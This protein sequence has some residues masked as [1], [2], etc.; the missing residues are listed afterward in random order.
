MTRPVA[1]GALAAA[2]LL[3]ILLSFG[4]NGSSNPTSERK[5]PRKGAVDQPGAAFSQQRCGEFLEQAWDML[6]PDRL[7]VSAERSVA[8]S[9]LNQWLLGCGGQ[10][11]VAS[12]MEESQARLKELIAPAAW[13]RTQEQ[14]FALRDADHI[15]NAILF[16]EINQFVPAGAE[17]DVQRVARLFDYVVRNVALKQPQERLPLTPHQILMFGRGSAED[18][19]WLFAELLRQARIDSVVVRP[20]AGGDEASE[21][22]AG[23]EWYVGAVLG[24]DVYLFDPRRGAPVPSAS[25]GAS[26]AWPLAPAKLSE[27]V[28]D[29]ADSAETTEA[30]RRRM[31]LIG[32]STYWSERMQKLQESLSGERSIVIYDPAVGQ[33][34]ERGGLARAEAAA[35]TGWQIGLWSYPEEQWLASESMDS[36]TAGRL[37]A[38]RAP[39]A[40][41]IPIANIDSDRQVELGTPL[42]ELRR[43]RMLQLSGKF[44][45]AIPSYLS[46]RRAESKPPTATKDTFIPSDAEAAVLAQLPAEVRETHRRAA[47]HALFWTGVAQME[48]GEDSSAYRTFADYLNRY[49]KEGVWRDHA[50]RLTALILIAFDRPEFGLRVV[51]EVDPESPQAAEL[52]FIAERLRQTVQRPAQDSESEPES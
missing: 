27:V 4:C 3:A 21:S 42:H 18:R 34:G 31:E 37:E 5:G 38:R 39:F 35:G 12:P 28:T 14:H 23:D 15:R 8:V 17:N 20:Q 25:A 11:D 19:A 46:I 30:Q 52:E 45:E 47:E 10:V 1:L 51:E 32:Y 33:G 50:R 6:Q 40:A 9:V 13:E 44:R 43:T 29:V 49:P 2:G 41:P 48:L 36:E 7:G 22:S 16:R 26:P 24:E